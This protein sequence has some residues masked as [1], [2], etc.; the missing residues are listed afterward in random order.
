M[1]NLSLILFNSEDNRVG[2]KYIFQPHKEKDKE[3]KYS[4][5]RKMSSG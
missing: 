3:K 2:N 5:I 1:K 4:E